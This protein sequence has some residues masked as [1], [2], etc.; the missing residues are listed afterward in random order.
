M[1]DLAELGRLREERMR[2]YVKRSNERIARRARAVHWVYRCYDTDGRLIYVGCTMELAKRLDTHHRSSWWADQV[3]NVK[4]TVHPNYA[5]AL[6]IERKAIREEHPR[7]NVGVRWQKRTD[8][9]EDQLRDFLYSKLRQGWADL[10]H[11][12]V[13][14]V[15]AQYKA[16][17]GKPLRDPRIDDYIWPGRHRYMPGTGKQAL[18]LIP[19]ADVA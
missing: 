8:W 16:R 15:Y 4:A 1:N 2:E 14:E 12:T 13:A 10:E 19:K 17:F 3:A 18:R 9:R 7:W 6:R 5:A 11:P